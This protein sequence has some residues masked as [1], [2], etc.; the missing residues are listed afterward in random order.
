MK[1][2]FLS[3][4]FFLPTALS[5]PAQSEL[6]QVGAA[7]VDMTPTVFP[8]QLRSGKSNYVHDPLHVR[9]VAFQRGD[10]RAVICLIDAIGIGRDMSDLA[11]ARAAP[12]SVQPSCFP[13][14]FEP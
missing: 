3:L 8:I 11:K 1:K 4:P 10:G 7:S 5:C 14:L 6:L 13:L 9:A 2:P 12:R